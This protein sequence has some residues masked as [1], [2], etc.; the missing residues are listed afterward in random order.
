MAYARN[1][2]PLD[3]A[4]RERRV[5]K[6][7]RCVPI[8]LIVLLFLVEATG[9]KPFSSQAH[10]QERTAASQPKQS[11]PVTVPSQPAN[12]PYSGE[13]GE[14][15]SEVQ[16]SPASRTVTMKLQVEDPNGYF[17]PNI[18]RENFAVY[19]D[20]IRQRNV[21][22]EVEHAPVTVALLL[23]FGG[24]YY[25]LDR[26][27]EMEVPRIGRK[28]LD[29]IGR[30]DKVAIFKYDSDLKVLADFSQGHETLDKI[31]DQ[32]GMPAIS[33]ANFYDV[34]LDALRRMREVHDRKAII[35][36]SS[37]IDSFSKASYQQVLEAAH[38]SATPIYA[39]GLAH[40]MRQEADLYGAA[41]P[42]ARIDWNTAEKQLEMFSKASGGRAY[43]PESD[44]EI[45]AIYD[46]IME[47][48]RIRYVITYVSSNPAASGPPRKIRVELI[49][50][51]TGEPLKIRD[52]NG[53]PVT[54]RVFVQESYTPTT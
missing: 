41:S 33:E 37:G 54:A 27:L 21:T 14:Q 36:V 40:T 6:S 10:G 45:P 24:R 52:S 1:L 50:P 48:L 47:N 30:D 49:D 31:F 15:R 13:Q 53:R 22:V 8:Y 46:N 29:F 38:D 4:P 23:E 17:L 9:Y 7:A 42:L 28:L 39:I 25:E 43:A 3:N 20:G 19:E 11:T 16:F 35:L 18:R 2:D 26:A 34:L 51:I 32:L 44:V 5:G 12:R